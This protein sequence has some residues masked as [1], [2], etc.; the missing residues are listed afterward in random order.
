MTASVFS[1]PKV[2]CQETD[3]PNSIASVN[4]EKDANLKCVKWGRHTATTDVKMEC[5]RNWTLSVAALLMMQNVSDS[6]NTMTLVA[7]AVVA[8]VAA[9]AAV[10]G[11]AA[12]VEGL[13]A[14]VAAAVVEVTAVAEAAAAVEVAEAAAVV[15]AVVA[16]AVAEAAAAAAVEVAEVV[17]APPAGPR[18]LIGIPLQVTLQVAAQAN[19]RSSNRLPFTSFQLWQLR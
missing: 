12:A 2:A 13:G 7:M 9:V 10:V 1:I 8:A 15:A 11:L 5:V 17:V 4:V 6:S 14:A 3:V 18:S 19:R 16:E